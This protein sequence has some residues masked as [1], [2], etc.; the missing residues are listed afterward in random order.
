MNQQILTAI[1]H[2]LD[3]ESWMWLHISFREQLWK[4]AEKL[5]KVKK[6]SLRRTC[7]S[8]FGKLVK[9]QKCWIPGFVSYFCKLPKSWQ[10]SKSWVS[11]SIRQCIH[12]YCNM[13]KWK[14]IQW[15]RRKLTNIQKHK[16]IEW[17][18]WKY[19]ET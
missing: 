15:S 6:L 8:N 13:R 12:I 17:H 3:R 14:E 16:D 19:M 1:R 11:W 10:K 7:E 4:A 2:C 18:I 5:T 9:S